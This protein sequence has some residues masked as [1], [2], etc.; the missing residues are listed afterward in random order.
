MVGGAGRAGGLRRTLRKSR[1]GLAEGWA[2]GGAGRG[3]RVGVAGERSGAGRV[4]L[5]AS[6]LAAVSQ[7]SRGARILTAAAL[8]L[9]ERLGACFVAAVPLPAPS[10]SALAQ[11]EGAHSQIPLRSPLARGKNVP[12]AVLRSR[13]LRPE[14]KNLEE[15]ETKAAFG[16]DELENWVWANKR[17]ERREEDKAMATGEPRGLEFLGVAP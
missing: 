15:E 2:P 10:A 3:G 8:A 9:G 16:T 5:S 6:L 11:R 14:V 1:E 4:L 13:A 12:P 17:C 7:L